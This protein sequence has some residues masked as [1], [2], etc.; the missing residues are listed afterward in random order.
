MLALFMTFF[1][2]LDGDK[3]ADMTLSQVSGWRRERLM[4][5]GE[6]VIEQVGGY[7]RGTIATA[8][9]KAAAVF[10]ILILFGVPLA[11][12]LTVVAFFAGLV[13]YLGAFITVII[14]T[15]AAIAHGGP[16]P[17]SSCSA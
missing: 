2:L 13:P 16:R 1:L 4:S 5:A 10:G 12:P 9:I 15:L 3:A 8:I 17:A 7:I 11:G 6:D 14:V